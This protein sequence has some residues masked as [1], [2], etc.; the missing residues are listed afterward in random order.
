M[1]TK[2]R[3]PRPTLSVAASALIG[4]LTS[5]ARPGIQ[6]VSG[7]APSAASSVERTRSLLSALAHDS[8]EGRR[9]GTPG[10]AR[11]ARY[12]ADRM[13]VIGLQPG[14]DSGYFQRIPLAITTRRVT[15]GGQ[16][17]TVIN[18][19]LFNSFAELDTVPRERRPNSVNVVGVIRGADPALGSE[20]VVVGAHYDHEGMGRPV[21]GDSI[22]NGADDDAS[23]I[24]AVLES[25]RIIG[26][27][28]KPKRTVVFIA[29]T[30]EE[31]GGFGVR[32]YADHPV[33]APLDKHVAEIQVEMIGRPDSMA[34]G[35]GKAWLTGYERSTMG[36]TLAN[37][38][39]A[40]VADPYPA[41]QFFMRSD[42]YLLARRGVI[43]Q[44]LSSFGMHKEYHTVDDEV[45]LV[46]FD[47]MTAVVNL[48]ARAVRLVA[49]G[50]RLEWKPGG[51]P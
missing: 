27:G 45:E 39:L 21:D 24:V 49:D 17:F 16:E 3:I 40:V 11:A 33:A 44:T 35:T 22:Y 36:E 46:D 30:G 41:Q 9:L 20:V 50:P 42:N 2:R 25:A 28:S 34:G 8:M 37:A 51:R 1:I 32:W 18:G 31:N 29:F 12:I 5:C 14:G 10:E 4:A 48:I 19:Q 43:A 38:G 26:A 47:H 7:P 15:R 6:V 13:R 23:G